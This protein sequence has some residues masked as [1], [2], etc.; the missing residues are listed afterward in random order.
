MVALSASTP[1]VTADDRGAAHA[2]A[3]LPLAAQ[4]AVSRALGRDDPSYD[5]RA[6]AGVLTLRNRG[7][8]LVARFDGRG[9]EVRS[10]R[11]QLGMSLVG[12][13][14]VD[15]LRPVAAASPRAQANR[16]EY[17]LGGL[18]GMR[19]GRWG[20]SRASRSRSGRRATSLVR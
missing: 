15:A 11:A 17:G 6:V 19:T 12:Y 1:R 7:Q 20:S 18:S 2:L 4:G 16:V 8:R 3:A 10:G 9:V 5:A 14:N 13:G